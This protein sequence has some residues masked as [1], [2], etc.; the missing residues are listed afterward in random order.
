MNRSSNEAAW[1]IFIIDIN[2]FNNWFVLLIESAL[3]RL[4]CKL[5]LRATMKIV[6]LNS[7]S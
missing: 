7:V 4:E 6:R 1:I 3:F 5:W 2:Y